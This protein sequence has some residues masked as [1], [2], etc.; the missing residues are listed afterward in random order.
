M[1][2]NVVVPRAPSR[3]DVLGSDVSHTRITE[4]V[5]AEF[6]SD[7]R[8]EAMIVRRSAGCHAGGRISRRH[9]EVTGRSVRARWWRRSGIARDPDARGHRQPRPCPIVA[10]RAWIAARWP[11][12]AI[13]MTSTWL[14]RAGRERATSTARIT[15]ATTKDHDHQS[16]RPVV[17]RVPTRAASGTTVHPPSEDLM[18]LPG[19]PTARG[20]FGQVDG[21]L[22]DA[23]RENPSWHP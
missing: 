16:T 19:K 18:A 17:L 13:A 8:L 6:V 20:A 3:G 23:A 1:Q 11:R 7:F 2:A 4:G 12:L 5:R 9:V 22:R 10:T 21:G 14:D 15:V